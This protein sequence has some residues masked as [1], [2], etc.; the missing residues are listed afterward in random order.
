MVNIM[1][2]PDS[3]ICPYELGPK[4]DE[5]L[6]LREKMSFTRSDIAKLVGVSEPTVMNWERGRGSMKPGLW[7]LLKIK[8]NVLGRARKIEK[9]W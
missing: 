2:I 5:L 9:G 1:T 4:P 3:L 8:I 6:I 7:E